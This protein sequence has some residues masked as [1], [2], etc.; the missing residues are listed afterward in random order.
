MKILGVDPST[1]ATGWGFFTWHDGRYIDPR[2][3]VLRGAHSDTRETR[4]VAMYEGMVRVIAELGPDIVCIEAPFVGRNMNTALAMGQVSGAI[5]IA[6]RQSGAKTQFYTVTEIR[7]RVASFGRA[8][9]SQVA[10]EVANLMGDPD[11]AIPFD[12]ADAL[13]VAV[14][15]ARKLDEVALVR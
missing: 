10:L 3:G 12:Q 2:S 11:Q 5:I 8:S 15:H 6:A 7:H 14:C 4:L 9:K 1:V 13:A